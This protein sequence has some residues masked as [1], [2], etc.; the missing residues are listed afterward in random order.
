MMLRCIS[1][2]E[3]GCDARRKARM[4]VAGVIFLALFLIAVGVGII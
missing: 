2:P 3:K 1:C 4:A